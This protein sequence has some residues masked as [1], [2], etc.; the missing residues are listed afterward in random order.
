MRILLLIIFTI[1]L[2][3]AFAQDENKWVFKGETDGIKV[4]HQ[5]TEGLSHVKLVTA[6]KVPLAGIVTMFSDVST[7]TNWAYKIVEA[8]RLRLVSDLEMYYYARFDFPWPMS[9]RDIIMHSKL[10]QNPKT[11]AI[12]ITNTSEPDYLVEVK[13]VQRIRKSITKWRFLP[14]NDGWVYTEQVISTDSAEGLPDWVV[15]LSIDTGPIETAINI[16]R[17]LSTE[18]FQKASLSYILE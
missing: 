4:Y 7:Y 5:R 2:V 13:G 8:N 15:K 12:S 18:R 14:G 10:E 17:I 3:T 9:D 16:R 1:S 6:L 11:K